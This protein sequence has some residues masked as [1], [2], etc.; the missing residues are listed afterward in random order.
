MQ[1]KYVVPTLFG[2]SS[3]YPSKIKGIVNDNEKFY[4]QEFASIRDYLQIHSLR[5][6]LYM[7][8]YLTISSMKLSGDVVKKS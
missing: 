1:N 7:I 5:F 3:V 2:I 4:C 6:C 8:D